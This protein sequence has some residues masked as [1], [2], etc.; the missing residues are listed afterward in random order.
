MQSVPYLVLDESLTTIYPGTNSS[1]EQGAVSASLPGATGI[2]CP[3]TA[4]QVQSQHATT[5]SSYL[6]RP[7]PSTTS[8]LA[9]DGLG[10]SG[11]SSSTALT[12]PPTTAIAL[13]QGKAFDSPFLHKLTGVPDDLTTSTAPPLPQEAPSTLERGL[14]LMSWPLRLNTATRLYHVS[15]LPDHLFKYIEKYATNPEFTTDS[16]ITTLLVW[17]QTALRIQLKVTKEWQSELGTV[18]LMLIRDRI[19]AH[20]REHGALNITTFFRLWEQE[21]DGYVILNKF[22]GIVLRWQRLVHVWTCQKER[23][24]GVTEI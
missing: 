23:G 1:H 21:G 12:S 13:Q 6:S 19:I 9:T 8:I 15:Y 16:R 2:S 18:S 11:G 5:V 22:R 24:S 3:N 7:N 17:S 20:Q 14:Y 4:R 10:G